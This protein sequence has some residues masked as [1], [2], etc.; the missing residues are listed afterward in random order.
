ML[1]CLADRIDLSHMGNFFNDF[2]IR[3]RDLAKNMSIIL[4][5]GTK[6]LTLELAPYNFSLKDY[7]DMISNLFRLNDL[8]GFELVIK[9][10]RDQKKLV[11]QFKPSTYKKIDLTLRKQSN[12]TII[13]KKK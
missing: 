7:N 8:K 11:S 9:F 10:N 4:P 1:I 13:I 2:T 5:S 3:A 6:K 12:D